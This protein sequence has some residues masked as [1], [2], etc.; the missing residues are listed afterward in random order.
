MDETTKARPRKMAGFVIRPIARKLVRLAVMAGT[1]ADPVR[2]VERGVS[3]AADVA[4]SCWCPFPAEI[5]HSPCTSV[6][7]FVPAGYASA[8]P[9]PR[10]AAVA[11]SGHPKLAWPADSVHLALLLRC[12]A[13]GDGGRTEPRC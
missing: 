9:M 2:L 13:H 10:P 7:G 8:G 11:D 4:L 1:L 5:Q 6:R 12:G 3:P